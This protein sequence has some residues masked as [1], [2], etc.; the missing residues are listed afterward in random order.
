[1]LRDINKPSNSIYA[2]DNVLNK[3][4]NFA[5]IFPPIIIE[6]HEQSTLGHD[7]KK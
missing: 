6:R 5:V 7:N 2:I 4:L 1:M 3:L